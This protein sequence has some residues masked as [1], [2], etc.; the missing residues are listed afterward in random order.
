M[1][2]LILT[3]KIENIILELLEL[4]NNLTYSDLQG[5]VKIKTWDII[6]LVKKGV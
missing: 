2:D 5:I 6:E 4:N 3:T 1:K